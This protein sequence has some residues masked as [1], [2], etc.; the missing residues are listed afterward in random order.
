MVIN[1]YANETTGEP[2]MPID[3]LHRVHNCAWIKFGSDLLFVQ[4][5]LK[6]AKDHSSVWNYA[7]I[8]NTQASLILRNLGISKRK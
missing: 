4:Y 7:G 1:E 8:S 3:A 5:W 2:L 6:T